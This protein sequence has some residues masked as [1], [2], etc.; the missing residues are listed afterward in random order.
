M[1]TQTA[2]EILKKKIN[3]SLPQEYNLKFYDT[4]LDAMHDHTTTL[5]EA[6]RERLRDMATCNYCS[7]NGYIV[8]I[9]AECCRNGEYE[10]CGIPNPIQVQR[11]CL[12]NNGSIEVTP[13]SIDQTINE[14]LKEINDGK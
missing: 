2:E 3:E 5:I 11:Q 7:G 13:E 1:K 6:L 12:C 8:D 14:F 9:E 4:A 10:C